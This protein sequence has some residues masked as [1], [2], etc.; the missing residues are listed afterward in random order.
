GQ[1]GLRGAQAARHPVAL[2]EL[3]RL[4][5][6]VANNRGQRRGNRPATRHAAAHRLDSRHSTNHTHRGH[7]PWTT[8]I[9]RGAR[10]TAT[11]PRGDAPTMTKI[12]PDGARRP[13]PAPGV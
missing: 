12:T 8:A 10:T 6:R 2:H 13:G 3:R 9:N 1:A 11:N 7:K 5:R 4:R